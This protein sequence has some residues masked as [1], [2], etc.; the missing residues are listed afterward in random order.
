MKPGTK[1]L[2]GLLPLLV[3]AGCGAEQGQSV[4]RDAGQ[5][6]GGAGGTGGAGAGGTG[7]GNAGGAVTGGTGAT[8]GMGGD[9]GAGGAQGL[10]DAGPKDAGP[11][12]PAECAD[13]KP[14]WVFCSDFESGS[15]AEWDDFDGN[16]DATNLLMPEP[17]PLSAED[18][19]VMRLRVPAGRGGA[20]LVKV[21]PSTYDRLFARW[22]VKWEKGFDFS[23]PNHGSGLHAGARNLL[24][25]SG[26][27]PQGND[28]FGAWLEH[29]TQTHRLQSYVYSVGMYQDC[30]DPSGACWGDVFPCTSDDGQNYC[31]KPQ[32]REAFDGPV[33]VEDRWYCVETLLSAGTPQPE[34]AGANGSINFWVDGQEQGPWTDLWL[35]TEADLKIGI[36][37]LSLFHH[38]DHSVAGMMFDH[39][40]VSEE[41]V[42]CL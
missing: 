3:S 33:L 18:N 1:I 17:G 38:G 24:G 22:Y 7:A 4:E 26:F 27:R 10:P 41:R 40:V 11:A 20:D 15:K 6:Q 35:R 13:P 9:S 34:A 29:S 21:L 2:S 28:W 32:H 14:A 19:H 12:N 8:S 30:A 16:P 23:A 39:V 31:T 25:R 36:L 37:W 42:G 5:A